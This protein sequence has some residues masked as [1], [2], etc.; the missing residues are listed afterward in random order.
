MFTDRSVV[1]KW[2]KVGDKET[3]NMARRIISE[4]GLLVGEW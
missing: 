3:F 4:E 2:I 1:D